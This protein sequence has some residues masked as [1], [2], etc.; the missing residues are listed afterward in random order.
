MAET[1][2]NLDKKQKLALAGLTIFGIFLVVLWVARLDSE[3][4]KP[5]ADNFGTAGSASANV[6]AT[7]QASEEKLKNQDTDKDGLSD[8][9]ETN[10]YHTSPYLPDS[11]SDG[12]PDGV[13]V[14]NGTDPN[15]PQGQVCNVPAPANTLTPSS[16]VNGNTASTGE[17]T[18]NALLLSGQIDAASLRQLLINSGVS[19]IDLDQI[20][21]ADLLK[22]YQDQLSSSSRKQ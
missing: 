22:S 2:N 3:I 9:E 6:A 10:V 15:C 17:D 11:D 20:S 12:I 16:T 8:W 19:K 13:E 18:L 14:K 4:K 7:D 1:K 21:D 5:L